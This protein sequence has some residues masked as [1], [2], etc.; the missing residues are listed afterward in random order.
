MHLPSVRIAE[1]TNL[2]IDDNQASQPS[3]EKHQIDP[4]PRVVDPQAALPPDESKVVAEFQQ[5]IRQM[6]DQR[7]LKI[8]LRVLVLD[9]EKL[10]DK[11]R[12]ASSGVRRSPA[13]FRRLS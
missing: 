8:R 13:G 3:M 9:V 11:S 10:E 4:E 6:L 12:I 2:E 7:L 5:E 1:A